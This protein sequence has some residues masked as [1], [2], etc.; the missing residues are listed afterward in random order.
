M[1]AL[2]RRTLVAGGLAAA[3]LTACAPRLHAGSGL[4]MPVDPAAT[5]RPDLVDIVAH[6]PRIRIDVRYATTDN[7]M[8]RILYPVARAMA[9]RPVADA[10]KRVQ[11]RAE[12]AGYGLLVHDAYRPWRITRMMWEATPPAQREFVA[13]PA[14]GSRHNRGCAID[15]TL[16]RDGR[17]LPMPSPYDDFTERAYRSY[18]GGTAEENA[19]R[20]RL[21]DWMVAEGFI[22]LPNEW[23]HFDWQG[24]QRYPIMD[25]PLI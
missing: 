10:L 1:T 5:A 21:E 3:F 7:F 17:A 11:D 19:N 24:W 8:R 2:D 23:W 4:R 22:P 13:N 14:T 20:Q 9:Q 18:Q 12:A 6:D 15:L 25:Q 16:H